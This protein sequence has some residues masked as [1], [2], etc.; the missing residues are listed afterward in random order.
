[1]LM[2]IYTD[3]LGCNMLVLLYNDVNYN[4]LVLKIA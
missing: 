1:M 3:C 4:M 2:K